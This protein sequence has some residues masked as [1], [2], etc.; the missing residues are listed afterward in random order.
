MLPYRYI[1]TSTIGLFPQ[2]I[3]LQAQLLMHVTFFSDFAD[4]HA[5]SDLKAVILSTE[6]Q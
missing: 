4:V 6:I 2:K 3:G 1:F 5:L